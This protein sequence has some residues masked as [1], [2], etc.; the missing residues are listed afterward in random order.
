MRTVIGFLVLAGVSALHTPASAQ[1]IAWEEPAYFS[2]RPMDDIGLYMSRISRRTGDA[3]GL[4]GI[5]R[6]SGN[7]NLGIRFGAA[8]MANAGES[9]LV[10]AELYG[11]LHSLTRGSPFDAA[12][13]VGGGAVFG[14]NYTQ[15]SM[16]IGF[17]LGARLGTGGVR[18]MPYVYPRIA[19]DIV[20]VDT[21]GGDRT[22]TDGVV[23]LDIGADLDLGERLIVRFA[24]S[25]LDRSAFGVGMAVRWPRPVSVSSRTR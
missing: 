3:T 19:L 21:S 2:P 24:G 10:G 8:D 20:S 23:A 17:S 5:W 15:F 9:V 18:L 22:D 1:R 12:W 25:V 7:L 13:I 14:D 4:S 6:Q 11:P 16:P